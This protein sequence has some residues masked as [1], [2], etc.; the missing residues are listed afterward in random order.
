VLGSLVIAG[1]T[2]RYL[3]D[4]A[5]VSL[6]A[7]DIARPDAREDEICAAYLEALLLGQPPPSTAVALT[8]DA[9]EWPDWFP[10]RDAE[11]ACELDR[12]AFALP[13]VR[14]DGLLIARPVFG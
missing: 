4:R 2:A 6:V 1:A 11:L 9:E 10:R 14:E 3:R 5:L 8:G 13:V 7:T 12:F